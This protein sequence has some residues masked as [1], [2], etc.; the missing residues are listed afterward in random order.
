MMQ[1]VVPETAYLKNMEEIF[2]FLEGL[3]TFTAR[4]IVVVAE[5]LVGKDRCFLT[6]LHFKLLQM[7]HDHLLDHLT[8][9]LRFTDLS[10]LT[11]EDVE[12]SR[13]IRDGMWKVI[14]SCLRSFIGA[15]F[16]Q[17]SF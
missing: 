16:V 5:F 3:G 4:P 15:L 12:E 10:K 17:R 6:G 13:E 11:D 7:G 1:S 8:I 14:R 2:D 9:P